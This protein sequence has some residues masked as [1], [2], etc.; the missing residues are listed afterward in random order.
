[1]KDYLGCFGTIISVVVWYNFGFVSAAIS[2]VIVI[3][4][5][6]LIEYIKDKTAKQ[7]QLKAQQRQLDEKLQKENEEKRTQQRRKYASEL[8]TKLNN[9]ISQCEANLNK[10]RN[11]LTPTY[12]SIDK[13][14]EMW[15]TLNKNLLNIEKLESIVAELN[16]MKYANDNEKQ[17]YELIEKIENLVAERLEIALKE[18]ESKAKC[19]M[20]IEKRMVEY[21]NEL[22]KFKTT[23]QENIAGLEATER[24][25]YEQVID[26]K[27]VAGEHK[28][29]L[30]NLLSEAKKISY[31]QKDEIS[32]EEKDR[33]E[34]ALDIIKTESDLE[35][36]ELQ[37]AFSSH[38]KFI[39]YQNLIQKQQSI[40]RDIRQNIATLDLD[41]EQFV[42]SIE[43]ITKKYADA[44]A[45]VSKGNFAVVKPLLKE[46]FDE[47]VKQSESE[48][49]GR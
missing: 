4:L 36:K 19:E 7:K 34:E 11:I 1:M 6:K 37:Y 33:E 3:C 25:I 18:N 28:Y 46:R 31:S 5:I 39:E 29:A 26:C 2:F 32:K 41:V 14:K 40:T 9:V 17:E 38:P 12:E 15:N 42:S 21:K 45:E 43:Q 48:V 27:V 30:E 22:N 16:A 10:S 49:K 24:E 44:K 8:K 20:D 13:Q 35:Y 47:I 23:V